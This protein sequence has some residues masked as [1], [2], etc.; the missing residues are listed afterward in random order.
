MS[1]VSAAI[2]ALRDAIHLHPWWTDSLLALVLIFISTGSVIFGGNGRQ[3]RAITVLDV[4]LVPVTTLPIAL[5]RYRP[6]AV[7]AI[8]V[9]A[10]T[11]LL[12]F[13]SRVQVPFGVIVAL[14]TVASRCE[15]RT[16]PPGARDGTRGRAVGARRA[17]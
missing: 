17:T 15:R 9:S 7:L 10:E 3:A 4:V 6:L 14:Y 12:L 11:A 8:T 13:S 16:R 2:G 1:R 5:R